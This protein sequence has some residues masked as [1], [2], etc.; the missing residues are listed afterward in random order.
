MSAG[1]HFT[2]EGYEQPYRQQS[3]FWSKLLAS[4][5]RSSA[6]HAVSSLTLKAFFLCRYIHTEFSVP[7]MLA[8][9]PSF[10]E[11]S[12]ELFIICGPACVCTRTFLFPGGAWW[13]QRFFTVLLIWTSSRIGREVSK[14]YSEARTDGQPITSSLSLE[15]LLMILQVFLLK[16]LISKA[17]VITLFPAFFPQ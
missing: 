8:T 16:S 3:S 15:F 12:V 1:F 4:N 14:I 11:Y 7:L 10:R 13:G 6:C 5:G 9:W 2:L 17:K